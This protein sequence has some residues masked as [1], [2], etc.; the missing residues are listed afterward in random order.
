M[1]ITEY[2]G[3]VQALYTFYGLLSLYKSFTFVKSLII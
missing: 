3:Q 1:Q 2:N